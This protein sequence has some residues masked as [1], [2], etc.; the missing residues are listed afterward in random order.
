MSKTTTS[1]IVLRIRDNSGAWWDYGATTYAESELSEARSRCQELAAHFADT[2][3][4]RV[5]RR[6]VIEEDITIEVANG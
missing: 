2:D 6:T 3:A 4:L 1:V 5:Y